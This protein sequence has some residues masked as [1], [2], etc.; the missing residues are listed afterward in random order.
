[1]GTISLTLPSDGDT[2][3]AADVNNPFNTIANTING[4]IDS[5][6]VTD[7]GLTPA[8]LVSGTGS[9][10]AWQSWTPSYTNFTIGNGTVNFAKYIQIGKTVFF[11]WKATLGTTTSMTDAVVV[12]LPVTVSA[13]FNFDVSPLIGHAGYHD[14]SSGNFYPLILIYRTTGT[15]FGIGAIQSSGTYGVYNGI[16]SAAVPVAVGT[17]DIIHAT[18]FY[19]AA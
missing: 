7:G 6:N 2:I 4:G 11:T 10:W 1:L 18:G 3:E 17:G 14:A 13:Q 16:T 12:S 19:E 5:N 9:S 15:G 8:D